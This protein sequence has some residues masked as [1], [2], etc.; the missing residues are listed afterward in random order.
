[1]QT[2]DDILK[3]QARCISHEIRNQV[4]ICDVYCEIIRKH[5]Q[6]N[7]IELPPV[8][9]AINCIMKSLKMVLNSLLDLKSLSN[10]ECKKLDL[11]ELLLQGIELS[12]VY[13]YEKN[14]DITLE[15]KSGCCVYIDENK[16][17]AVIVNLIK[18]AIEAIAETGFINVKT[19]I[20]ED[21]VN[22]KISNNGEKIPDD[23][24]S[25]IFD[26]GL[27]TKCYG[28]GLGLYICKNNLKKMD[29]DLNLIKS[30][31]EITE[32]EIS[33]PLKVS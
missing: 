3:T 30:T 20:K 28:S 26:E 21:Y 29:A 8:D 2:T 10:F 17:L 31:D 14:I 7:N 23:Y 27:T 13:V 1:M 9:N 32:F 24:I 22:V 25:K 12:K 19:E 6:K 15:C 33:L 18:N 16:F 5:L 4:S 11:K